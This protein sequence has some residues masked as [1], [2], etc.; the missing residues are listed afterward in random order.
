MYTRKNGV[1]ALI[2]VY[3]K[4]TVVSQIRNYKHLITFD[5]FNGMKRELHKI[6]FYR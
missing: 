1:Y 3:F 5:Y 4:N 6:K 2:Y